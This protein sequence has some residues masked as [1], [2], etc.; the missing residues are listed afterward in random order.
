MKRSLPALSSLSLSLSLGLALVLEG[1]DASACGRGMSFMPSGDEFLIVFGATLAG[2]GIIAGEVVFTAHDASRAGL[3]KE[4]D[5]KWSKAETYFT[6]PQVVLGATIGY[7]VNEPSAMLSYM[8]WPT[9][10]MVHGFY[11]TNGDYGQKWQLPL[12]ILGTMDAGL[13]GYVHLASALGQPVSPFYGA[14]EFLTGLAQLSFG[15]SYAAQ[16]DSRTA[17]DALLVDLVPLALMVHGYF[18]ADHTPS[19]DA[20][21]TA[22]PVSRGP[23]VIPST[24]V[25][26]MYG[27]TP[28][29]SLNGWF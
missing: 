7:A 3:D 12:G 11:A 4:H 23:R 17:R 19:D 26:G 25:Q 18:V 22:K 9:S 1:R 6:I 28:G 21:K 16:S 24:M 14:G 15:L 13:I 27:P 8:A 29:L 2:T 20:V 10:L 5:P